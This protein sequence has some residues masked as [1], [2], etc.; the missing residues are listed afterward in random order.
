MNTNEFKDI[1]DYQGF[2]QKLIDFNNWRM[3]PSIEEALGEDEYESIDEK[4]IK[5]I[6]K[7]YSNFLRQGISDKNPTLNTYGLGLNYT[8]DQFCSFILYCDL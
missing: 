6:Q 3:D 7:H 5:Y 4:C 2:K 8:F 1:K